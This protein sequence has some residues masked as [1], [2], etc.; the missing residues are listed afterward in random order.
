M[1]P[2]SIAKSTG[3][4]AMTVVTGSNIGLKPPYRNTFA[5]DTQRDMAICSLQCSDPLRGSVKDLRYY[6]PH[7]TD[8]VECMAS[9]KGIS[10]W[11]MPIRSL[12][13][14]V[15]CRYSI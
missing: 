4:P 10:R 9:L 7:T 6:I 11:S 5:P 2:I 1:L 13:A 8:A 3:G 14:A 12:G 15:P